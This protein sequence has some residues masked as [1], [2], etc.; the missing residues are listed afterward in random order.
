MNNI[1]ALVEKIWQIDQDNIKPSSGMGSY[2][3][4]FNPQRTYYQS[5]SPQEK[6]AYED[7]VLALCQAT[8]IERANLGLYICRELS[9]IFSKGWK[10]RVIN[11]VNNLVQTKLPPKYNNTI[12]FAVI[13]LIQDFEITSLI[14]LIIDYTQDITDKF[15]SG[16]LPR[17]EWVTFYLQ[18][19]TILI[20]LSPEKFWEEFRL[21]NADQYLLDLLKEE[22]I[23]S[24]VTIWATRGALFR[25]I[26]W[27]KLMALEYSKSSDPVIKS[28]AIESIKSATNTALLYS[29]SE[30]NN[31]PKFI[32]WLNVTLA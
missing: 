17:F 11:L 26:E 6:M 30:K 4:R 19:C 21:F 2:G 12:S 15:K 14:P 27:L 16:I 9:D 25:G 24:I 8:D 18:T 10:D 28:I 5:L 22:N 32:E 7:A 20:K 1:T 13:L 29:H 23:S 3:T 31:I